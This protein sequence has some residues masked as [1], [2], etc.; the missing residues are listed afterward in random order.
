MPGQ[1]LASLSDPTPS[2][3]FLLLTVEF[4][5]QKMAYAI[6]SATD[7]NGS[8]MK[9]CFPVEQLNG[10]DSVISPSFRSSALL[11]LIDSETMAYLNI[12]AG[13]GSCAAVPSCIDAIVFS[14]GIGRGLFNGLKK[15]GIRFFSSRATTVRS[16]LIELS[17]GL[18]QEV[19]EVDCCSGGP[20][21]TSGVDSCCPHHG[22]LS[23]NGGGCCA[24]H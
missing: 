21:E 1:P 18:L 22:E 8:V 15:N 3:L 13:E 19:H 2:M 9:L 20:H 11:M 6:N 5:R 17:S 16:A 10:L 4:A 23:V 24:V 14:E 7:L 12:D